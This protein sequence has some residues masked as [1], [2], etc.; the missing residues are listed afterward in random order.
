MSNHE[1]HGKH[2]RHRNEGILHEVQIDIERELLEQWGMV[3]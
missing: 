1:I 2:G 3:G